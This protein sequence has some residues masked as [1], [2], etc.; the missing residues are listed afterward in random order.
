MSH[1]SALLL[2]AIEDSLLTL[3]RHSEPIEWAFAISG[4]PDHSQLSSFHCN[5]SR[6]IH[7]HSHVAG[8]ID[9]VRILSHEGQIRLWGGIPSP[10]VTVPYTLPLDVAKRFYFSYAVHETK[11]KVRNDKHQGNTA[12][13]RHEGCTRCSRANPSHSRTTGVCSSARRQSP[14]WV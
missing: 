9:I 2:H 4:S 12:V 10:G 5:V 13:Q 6:S 1:W 14:G 11:I 3:N 7:G 8:G